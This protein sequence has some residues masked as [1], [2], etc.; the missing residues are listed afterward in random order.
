M[1]GWDDRHKQGGGQRWKDNENNLSSGGR[2]GGGN[3]DRDD[4]RYGN[5]NNNNNNNSSNNTN[6]SNWNDNKSKRDEDQQRNRTQNRSREWDGQKSENW[7]SAACSAAGIG[8]STTD[9]IKSQCSNEEICF[10]LAECFKAGNIP[11]NALN[12]IANNMVKDYEFSSKKQK[13]KR[14]GSE[15]PSKGSR[16][17]TACSKAKPNLQKC[18]RGVYYCSV[19]CQ[20]THWDTHEEYCGRGDENN[21][22]IHKRSPS[23][24]PQKKSQPKSEI[25]REPTP[26]RYPQPCSDSEFASRMKWLTN[27]GVL[28][29]DECFKFD[30]DWDTRT[31]KE[32]EE[33]RLYNER[34]AVKDETMKRMEERKRQ[35]LETRKEHREQEYRDTDYREP[36][37]DYREPREDFRRHV[38]EEK[39]ETKIEAP[40]ERMSRGGT[41]DDEIDFEDDHS[42]THNRTPVKRE[43]ASELKQD[44]RET[45]LDHESEEDVLR[46]DVCNYILTKQ[47]QQHPLLKKKKI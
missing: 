17:C 47:Q 44:A 32:R 37:E 6:R 33:I 27:D 34:M 39:P 19:E 45:K 40:L 31:S 16:T 8:L 20:H 29:K 11:Q 38:S 3:R 13:R 2:A 35:F 22:K 10:I 12:S 5:N 14:G 25:S 7:V 42:S 21:D 30:D 18:C 28:T 43:S 4:R 26:P 36:R 23:P 46:G 24:E 1:S 9:A 15:E 41:D